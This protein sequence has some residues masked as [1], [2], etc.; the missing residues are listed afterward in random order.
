MDETQSNA[1]NGDITPNLEFDYQ[2]PAEGLYDNFKTRDRNGERLIP[3][4]KPK[5]ITLF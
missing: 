1:T 4:N 3:T 2:E 5:Q